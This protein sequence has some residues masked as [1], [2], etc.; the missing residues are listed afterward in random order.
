MPVAR[1]VRLKFTRAMADA[2]SRMSTRAHIAVSRSEDD[3]FG[4]ARQLRVTIDG[5]PAGGV[6]HA[7]RSVFEVEPGPRQVRV[8]MDWCSSEPV[9]VQAEAGQTIEL[10]ARTRCASNPLM[11]ALGVVAWPG[12]FFVV[13]PVVATTRDAVPRP[14]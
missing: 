2:P 4:I 1:P 5:E 3:A 12:R 11:N 13:E 10:D 14:I 9:S 8:A 6:K 7:D